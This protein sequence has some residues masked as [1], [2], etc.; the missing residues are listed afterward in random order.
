MWSFSLLINFLFRQIFNEWNAPFLLRI[1]NNYAPR[2]FIFLLPPP[3]PGVIY[4]GNIY[5]SQVK[6]C[7]SWFVR[8]ICFSTKTSFRVSFP[9]ASVVQSHAH[10][11]MLT[12]CDVRYSFRRNRTIKPMTW[13]N[14]CNILQCLLNWNSVSFTLILAFVYTHNLRKCLHFGKIRVFYT[15]KKGNLLFLTVSKITFRSMY[16]LMKYLLTKAIPLTVE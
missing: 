5:V 6:R 3:P 12:L 11:T 9:W 8:G 13:V 15:W 10:H 16:I 1:E 14:D 7:L 4:L 2:L